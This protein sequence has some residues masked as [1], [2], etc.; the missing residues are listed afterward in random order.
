MPRIARS[1]CIQM[2]ESVPPPAVSASREMGRA[3]NLD[4]VICFDMGGTTAKAC[5]L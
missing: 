4:D 1:Q 2:L 3:M 5:V